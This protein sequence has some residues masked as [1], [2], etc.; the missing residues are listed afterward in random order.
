MTG[1]SVQYKT[2]QT[3]TKYTYDVFISYAHA[4]DSEYIDRFLSDLR[5]AVSLQLGREVLLW[6]DKVC[7]VSKDP[8]KEI[9]RAV[10][11]S[12]TLLVLVSRRSLSREWVAKEYRLFNSVLNSGCASLK[13][14]VF[15]ALIDTTEN[16]QVH[17]ALA[18]LQEAQKDTDPI[19]RF[20][21]MGRSDYRYK[22]DAL[23][24]E[25][26]QALSQMELE[27]DG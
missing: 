2:R 17:E 14:R 26:A 1:Q 20:L 6:Q 24:R 22:L 21:K 27:P 7:M 18:E 23:A 16:A 3:M 19:I 12:A 13:K 4:D 10:Q 11:L 5:T 15:K 8:E 25:I 9:Q